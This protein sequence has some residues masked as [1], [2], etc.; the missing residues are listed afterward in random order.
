[1]PLV[2]LVDPDLEIARTFETVVAP[3][4][5]TR[6]CRDFLTARQALTEFHPDLVVA[7]ARLGEYNGLHLA[8]IARSAGLRTRA[9]IY[10]DYEDVVL[11]REVRAMGGFFELQA[12]LS[13]TLVAYLGI[14]LP[15]ADRR[16]GT[17]GDRRQNVDGG[18][19][20]ADH[21]AAPRDRR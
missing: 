1:M 8:Y 4:A 9:I 13:Q 16:D 12:T 15:W 2:L 11:A 17:L 20:P 6:T 7:N 21:P 14:G 5:S 10:T 3:H 18:R 19:R